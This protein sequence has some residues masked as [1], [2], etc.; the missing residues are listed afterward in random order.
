M[1]IAFLL[2]IYFCKDWYEI[3]LHQCL[4]F[5]YVYKGDKEFKKQNYQEDKLKEFVIIII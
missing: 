4:G 5:Y 1:F 2:S 3:K